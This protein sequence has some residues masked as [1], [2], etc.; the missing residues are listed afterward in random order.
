M[1]GD[2]VPPETSLSSSEP[3]ALMT[4]VPCCVTATTRVYESSSDGEDKR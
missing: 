2:G 1:Q 3:Q 4:P